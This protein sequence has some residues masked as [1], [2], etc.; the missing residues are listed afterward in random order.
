MAVLSCLD[1]RRKFAV[2]GAK[3]P[4]QRLTNSQDPFLEDAHCFARF[5]HE[6]K[7]STPKTRI[8]KPAWRE[9][10]DVLRLHGFGW[11]PNETFQLARFFL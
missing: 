10:N 9:I 4:N 2:I 5:R 7:S 3:P 8:G 1:P 6:P 11:L